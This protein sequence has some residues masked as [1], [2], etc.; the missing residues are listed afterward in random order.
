MPFSDRIVVP[1]SVSAIVKKDELKDKLHRKLTGKVGARN[2]L[3]KL[4]DRYLAFIHQRHLSEGRG[5]W[6]KLSA[7]TIQ[8]RRNSKERLPNESTKVLMDTLQLLDISSVGGRGQVR[9]LDVTTMIARAGVDGTT[10]YHDPRTR[11]GNRGNRKRLKPR[12]GNTPRRI[13]LADLVNYHANGEPGGHHRT[14]F[15]KPDAT[16]LPGLRRDAEDWIKSLIDAS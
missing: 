5:R 10:V 13:T 16:V 6:A 15:S 1:V 12:T 11:I 14:I 3:G 4:A 2:L 8:R 9:K 7:Y